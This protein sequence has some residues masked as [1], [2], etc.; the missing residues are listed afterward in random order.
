MQIIIIQAQKS[1]HNKALI[2]HKHN[3]VRVFK[4]NPN[5]SF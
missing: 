2:E 5:I 3:F 4:C 1:T